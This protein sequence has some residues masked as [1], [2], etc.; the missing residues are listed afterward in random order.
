MGYYLTEKHWLILFHRENKRLSKHQLNPYNAAGGP[1]SVLHKEVWGSRINIQCGNSRKDLCCKVWIMRCSQETCVLSQAKASW[2]WSQ[3]PVISY[4]PE[5]SWR[6]CA[7][8]ERG[9]CSRLTTQVYVQG[10]IALDKW[11]NIVNF[12]MVMVEI[13]QKGLTVIGWESYSCTLKVSL[14]ILT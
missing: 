10:A 4:F 6:K 13:I 7:R 2:G 9:E 14:Q 1:I 5:T 12:D 8:S 11:W 3:S